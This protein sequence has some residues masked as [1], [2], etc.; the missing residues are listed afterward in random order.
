MSRV[1]NSQDIYNSHTTARRLEADVAS[2]ASDDLSAGLREGQRFTSWIIA[3]VKSSLEKIQ[4]RSN[5]EATMEA[6]KENDGLREQMVLA[7]QQQDQLQRVLNASNNASANLENVMLEVRTELAEAKARIVK[8]R[9][10]VAEEQETLKT[11]RAAFQ[12]ENV[13]CARITRV[14]DLQ[15][16]DDKLIGELWDSEKNQTVITLAYREEGLSADEVD[17]NWRKIASLAEPKMGAYCN[18]FPQLSG[19]AVFIRPPS[20]S[21]QKSAPRRAPSA[22]TGPS[23]K[24]K[25]PLPKVTT[26]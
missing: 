2:L 19:S 13:L 18:Y 10:N 16:E 11:L 17:H 5:P 24:T 14:S 21:L 8:V 1:F 12:L 9:S 6:S 3:A 7:T 26:L 4:L 23:K 25:S 20:S 15:R 22:T